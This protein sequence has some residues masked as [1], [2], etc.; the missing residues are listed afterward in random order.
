MISPEKRAELRRLLERYEYATPAKELETREA[1]KMA[2]VR[3]LPELLD[4]LDAA[5]QERDIDEWGGSNCSVCGS[6]CLY[7]SRHPQCG[8][9]VMALEQERDR[10]RSH[11][12][13]L[14][15]IV[16]TAVEALK[17]IANSPHQSYDVHPGS[18]SYDRQYQIGVADGHRCA[19]NDALAALASIEGGEDE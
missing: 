4:A 6:P 15:L 16:S 5:E 14:R 7:G 8:R 9:A 3:A 18:T 1:L 11:R 12:D 13:E 19:G 2:A 10:L 17:R